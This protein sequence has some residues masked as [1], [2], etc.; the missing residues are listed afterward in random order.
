LK[1]VI[2]RP[3]YV[4]SN[5]H[6]TLSGVNTDLNGDN[7]ATDIILLN[8]FDE[9]N[10]P[11]CVRAGHY[12]LFEGN[13]TTDTLNSLRL[14]CSES[15]DTLSVSSDSDIQVKIDED[16]STSETSEVSKTKGEGKISKSKKKNKKDSK[17]KKEKTKIKN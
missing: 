4:Y 17:D 3:I 16:L 10:K 5:E 11:D 6:N 12:E 2:H 8:Y 7:I 15:N 1:E 13:I 9:I 14:A